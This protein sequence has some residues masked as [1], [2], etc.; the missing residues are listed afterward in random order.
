[1]NKRMAKRHAYE[2][3]AALLGRYKSMDD[4]PEECDSKID[5]A[6]E[7]IRRSLLAR[8]KRMSMF[9]RAKP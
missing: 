4:I 6:I 9:E 8:A 3:A 1:M 5:A 7:E 2:I